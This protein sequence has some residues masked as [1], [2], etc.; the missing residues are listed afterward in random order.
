[1][2]Y[3]L[4]L[5]LLMTTASAS[6]MLQENTSVQALDTSKLCIKIPS[7]Q[8]RTQNIDENIDLLCDNQGFIVKKNNTLKRVH[9]YDTETILRGKDVVQ[10]AKF[11]ACL[12]KFKVSQL[13]NGDFK[14][15]ANCDLKGGGPFG[16]TMGFYVGRLGVSFIG[17]GTILIISG[18]TGPAA[19]ATFYAL[20][21]TFGPSI[22]ASAN[23][24]GIGLAIAVGTGTGP[25]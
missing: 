12:S 15:Y 19:K 20:E 11:A 17:H 13:D 8:V 1:M 7:S 6:A 25:V 14:L 3:I 22:E 23:A 9:S 2:I 18:L 16:A 4:S 10:I 24:A 5:A 21:S